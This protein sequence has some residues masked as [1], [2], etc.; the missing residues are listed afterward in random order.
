MEWI[1]IEWIK[2]EWRI[3]L[4]TYKKKLKSRKLSMTVVEKKVE[5]LAEDRE[6][7]NK[8]L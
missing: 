2:P 7:R 5:V 1:P 6:R 3:V 4:T 8:E